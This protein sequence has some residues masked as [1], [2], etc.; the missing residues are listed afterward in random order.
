MFS[1]QNN[2]SLELIQRVFKIFFLNIHTA[3]KLPVYA[4]HIFWVLSSVK[5]FAFH[6]AEEKEQ[7]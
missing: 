3:R 5:E 2:C 1:I 6:K 7:F 4:E